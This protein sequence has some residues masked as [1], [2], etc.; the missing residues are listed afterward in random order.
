TFKETG[1]RVMHVEEPECIYDQGLRTVSSPGPLR[2]QTADSKFRIEGVG[3]RWQQTNTSLLISNRVHTWVHPDVLKER[4][5]SL[6]PANMP[7]MDEGIEITSD[8]F[9]FTQSRL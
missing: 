9:E 5:A 2:V 6:A 3:F 7:T 1:E 8:T 4:S